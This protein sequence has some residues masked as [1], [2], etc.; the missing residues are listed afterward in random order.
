L[1]ADEA[2]TAAHLHGLGHPVL[3][4]LPPRG[5]ERGEGGLEHR[6]LEKGQVAEASQQRLKL[7]D[8]RRE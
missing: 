2:A 3:R 8:H 5:G 7:I 1:L 4:L 6:P